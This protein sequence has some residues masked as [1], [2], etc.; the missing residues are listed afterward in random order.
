MEDT[1]VLELERQSAPTDR[2]VGRCAILVERI[3]PY[4]F[5]RLQAL[6]RRLPLVAIEMYDIDSTYAWNKVQQP[7]SF[8]RVTLANVV[9]QR[10]ADNQLLAKRVVSTLEQLAP[11]TVFIPGWSDVPSLTALRW[12]VRHRTPAVVLTASSAVGRTRTGWRELVKKRVVRLF[13]A[14]V[15]GGTPQREYLV[16]L[17]LAPERT[18]QGCTVV[19]NGYFAETATAARRAAE[20]YR[21][22]LGLPGN[23]FL[24]IARFIPEKNLFGLLNAYAAYRR[25]AKA[26]VWKLVLLGDGPLK[27]PLL[28]ERARLGLG[29]DVLMPGFKQYSELPSYYGLAGAFVLPSVSETWGLVINEA[30]AAELPVLVSDYCGCARDL[31]IPGK[32]GFTFH[33][34][35]TRGL[36]QRM[37]QFAGGSC[38]LSSMGRHSR[39]LI[40]RWSPESL[41]ETMCHAANAA[42]AAPPKRRL[43]CV[44]DALL[45]MLLA[46]RLRG[47]TVGAKD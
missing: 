19:D 45:R 8:A 3:G 12:C 9:G 26:N 33:P 25:E 34:H 23:F 28:E 7:G 21:A 35:D 15:G 27:A 5:A 4:H 47:G 1:P 43:S 32:N 29:E 46:Q 11:S 37:L 31:V 20:S 42:Q 24:T 6:G 13:S 30:M 44:D 16:R 14:G 40:E 17:G 41:A 39:E 38:D 2:S 18:F 22:S 10:R 36:A